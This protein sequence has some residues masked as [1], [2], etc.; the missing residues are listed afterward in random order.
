MSNSIF[1]SILH[2]FCRLGPKFAWKSEISQLHELIARWQREHLSPPGDQSMHRL[3][4]FS[5]RAM[6]TAQRCKNEN[7]PRKERIRTTNQ[8]DTIV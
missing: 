7:I 8:R 5:T 3:L 1:I 4:I 2:A 6:K